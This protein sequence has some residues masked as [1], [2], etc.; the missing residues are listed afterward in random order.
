M[1]RYLGCY[2]H[3]GFKAIYLHKVISINL[4][5]NKLCWTCKFLPK[6]F[7]KINSSPAFRS[8]SARRSPSSP[9]S[10][11]CPC[12]SGRSGSE[13][14]APSSSSH[15]SCGKRSSLSRGEGTRD[16]FCLFSDSLK[17]VSRFSQW[18]QGVPVRLP[19]YLG[20]FLLSWIV[21]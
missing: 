19:I 7:Y 14:W 17:T 3:K 11:S 20:F 13:S 2:N 15:S 21:P 10:S 16:L 18:L 8:C 5:L 12:S 6:R 1:D 9:S 4:N